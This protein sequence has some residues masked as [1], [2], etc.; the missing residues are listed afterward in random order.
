M[1]IEELLKLRLYGNKESTGDRFLTKDTSRP[2]ED[3]KE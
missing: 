1:L 3:L 2:L